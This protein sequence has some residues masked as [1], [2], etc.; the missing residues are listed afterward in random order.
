MSTVKEK[1]REDAL[2]NEQ[3]RVMSERNEKAME[4]VEAWG[5]KKNIVGEKFIESAMEAPEKFKK[6]AVLL[7]NFE[8]HVS[9]LT[10]AQTSA[11]FKGLMPTTV[12]KIVRLGYPNSVR[13]DIFHEWAMQTADDSI[14][15]WS[16]IYATTK[17][18]GIAGT[19]THET[20]THDYSSQVTNDIIAASV[21][22]TN[23]TGTL[24]VPPIIGDNKLFVKIDDVR[25]ASDLTSG[26]IS[27]LIPDAL[28]YTSGITVVGTINYTTGDYDVTFSAAPT[29]AEFKI[30]FLYDMEDAS[31]YDE[32]GEIHWELTRKQFQ[33]EFHSLKTAWSL[34]SELILQKSMNI[35]LQDSMVKG[36]ADELKKALDFKTL[37]LGATVAKGNGE[38]TFNADWRTSSSASPSSYAQSLKNAIDRMVE[39]LYTAKQRGEITH[40][41][42]TLSAVNYAKYSDKWVSDTSSR[43]IGA[44]LAGTLDGIKVY[45]VPNSIAGD[46]DTLIGVFN[47]SA[48]DDFAISTGVLIPIA[49]NTEKLTYASLNSESA[50]YCVEQSVVLAPDY[51][52]KLKLENIPTS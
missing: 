14:Y 46:T 32:Q 50:T 38:S 12:M 8:G 40:L 11:A 6:L 29:G 36:A 51:L 21:A 23:Y 9:N 26:V 3:S 18:D 39:N 41:Y 17:R 47:N 5:A 34:K 25:V 33:P 22:T 16:P 15:Y 30:E 48:Y 45:V 37:K 7:E 28:S 13:G 24:S 2:V 44:Y 10:E 35:D 20:S 42:G 49:A 52:M 19:V 4:L 27:G 43:K 31:N 1:M